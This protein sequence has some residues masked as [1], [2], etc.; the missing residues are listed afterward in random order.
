MSAIT[1]TQQRRNSQTSCSDL[2]YRR[3]GIR[4]P[5]RSSVQ[6]AAPITV[7]ISPE[8]KQTTVS[9]QHFM[10]SAKKQETTTTHAARMD[11]QIDLLDDL[12]E[13]SVNT[14][15]ISLQNLNQST[16]QALNTQGNEETLIL[17]VCQGREG[18]ARY[19]NASTPQKRQNMSSNQISPIMTQVSQAAQSVG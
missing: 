16:M 10:T 2:L 19:I 8:I 1:R 6:L 11:H 15:M 18:R 17:R 13:D 3:H 14:N 9:K 7:Q 12:E 4:A 5:S